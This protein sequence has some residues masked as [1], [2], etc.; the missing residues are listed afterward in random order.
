M[1]L[2]ELRDAFQAEVDNIAGINTYVMDDNFNINASHG[3]LYPAVW[4]PIP[5]STKLRNYP[6]GLGFERFTIPFT[7]Y[8]V[9]PDKDINNQIDRISAMEVLA[10]QAFRNIHLNNVDIVDYQADIETIRGNRLHNDRLLGVSIRL[11]LTVFTGWDC[12]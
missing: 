11:S 9:P 8:D 5:S 10:N 7:L 12:L 2:S 1:N 4:M 3:T 6:Q